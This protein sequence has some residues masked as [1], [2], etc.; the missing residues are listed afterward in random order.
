MIIRLIFV[1]LVRTKILLNALIAKEAT[2]WELAYVHNVQQV[3]WIVQVQV[4]VKHVKMDI[5]LF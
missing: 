5:I 3:V 1:V 4:I 2:I